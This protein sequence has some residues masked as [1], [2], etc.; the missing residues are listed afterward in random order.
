MISRTRLVS[1][2]E[3]DFLVCF[4][5][6][7]YGR[8]SC[9]LKCWEK[10][11]TLVFV[12][13]DEILGYATVSGVAHECSKEIWF[14]Q[15]Y[16]FMIPIVFNI[17]FEKGK[18]PSF[19]KHR[20]ELI[21][22][23]NRDWGLCF[24]NR[25]PIPEK[26]A[27]SILDNINRYSD[28]SKEMLADVD[29]RL[30]AELNL[31]TSRTLQRVYAQS[32]KRKDIVMED[33]VSEDDVDEELEELVQELLVFCGTDP[34]QFINDTRE[35]SFVRT[36]DDRKLDMLDRVGWDELRRVTGDHMRRMGLFR[37]LWVHYG[38]G[39]YLVIGE[40]RGEFTKQGMWNLIR[41]MN[42]FLDADRIF[43]I[44]HITDN[45]G[46]INHEIGKFDNM[47]V[48][49]R[50]NEAIDIEEYSAEF[51]ED[52]FGINRDGVFLGDLMVA[53][54]DF[55]AECMTPRVDSKTMTKGLFKKHVLLNSQNIEVGVGDSEKD[56][57]TNVRAYSG[58][59]CESHVVRTRPDIK[60]SPGNMSSRR[61]LKR[62]A[63]WMSRIHSRKY[64]LGKDWTQGLFVVNV[65]NNGDHTMVPCVIK[66][67]MVDGKEEYVTSYFD[68]IITET[69]VR[70]PDRK[71]F[72]NADV[73][74]SNHDPEILSIQDEVVRDYR[75]DT[76]VNLGDMINNEGFN[77]HKSKNG[78][79]VTDPV[80]DEAATAHGILRRTSKW[81][82]EC[83]ILLGNHERF[84]YDFVMQYPQFKG[85]VEFEFLC[86]P[87]S[88]GF[89]VVPLQEKLEFGKLSFYHGDAVRGG[90]AAVLDRYALT[91]SDSV[92]V[93]GHL[94]RPAIRRNVHMVGLT[95]LLDQGYNTT[96]ISNWCHGFALINE[97]AG[98]FFV[99]T[100]AIVNN[101]VCIN[102]KRYE[103][104]DVD[105]WR[106]FP[107]KPEISFMPADQEKTE[108][109]GK[110]IRH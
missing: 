29:L 64:H 74:A 5:N 103:P 32:K 50:I 71:F 4:K 38:P 57:M 2:S 90:T 65:D 36:L 88:A 40:S 94:H 82:R 18:R 63:G 81:A 54:Q 12:N 101:Q 52:P 89:N 3:L 14:S 79:V 95:G 108:W 97:F 85:M 23:Y 27:Y 30:A 61:I 51:E 55:A 98:E 28:C 21:D 20:Q 70:C 76:Y 73:H 16:S 66:K 86:S 75:P 53:N 67:V 68:T 9:Y 35:E 48:V 26:I 59:I 110:S 37:P 60:Y 45:N 72:V 109:R 62:I 96:S 44:G 84:A 17:V 7:L 107:W 87:A 80:L 105:K 19:V 15:N 78:E 33:K 1:V 93:I 83:Y 25:G 41:Q 77:H 11:D 46:L 22:V 10:G 34:D 42:D 13:G 100:L 47:V 91:C 106:T 49:S 99:S 69:G 56:E 6:G 43:H 92:V 58:C 39:T 8:N 31:D 104:G 24:G 102:G